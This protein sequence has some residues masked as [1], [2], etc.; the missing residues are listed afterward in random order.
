[1]GKPVNPKILN[2]ELKA[3]LLEIKKSQGK[4][5]V[6][7]Q[8]H[9]SDT[10]PRVDADLNLKPNFGS[11]GDPKKSLREISAGSNPKKLKRSSSKGSKASNGEKQ[12]KKTKSQDRRLLDVANN[13]SAPNSRG[14]KKPQA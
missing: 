1:M 5:K 2:R 6:G 14:K 3:I 10:S 12:L 8:S 4:G 11:N 13:D 7:S 9:N